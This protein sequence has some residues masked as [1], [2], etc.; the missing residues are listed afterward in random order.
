MKNIYALLLTLV[1]VSNAAAQTEEGVW[2]VGGTFTINTGDNRTTIALS[3][4]AGYFVMNNLAVGGNISLSHSKLGNNKVTTF[5]AGPLVRYYF[6]RANIKPFL[7]GEFGIVSEKFKVVN[8]SNTENGIHFLLALGLAGF[9]NQNVALEALA[10]YDHTRLKDF[11]GDGGFAF[12]LGF[13]VY[14]RP[15]QAVQQIRS[16]Q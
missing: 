13:Q 8:N 14:L 11:D 3:P 16:G 5:G 9:L 10:G 7:H 6:G 4:M 12:R 1:L 2:L 15:R